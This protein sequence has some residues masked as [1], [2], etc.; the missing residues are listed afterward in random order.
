MQKLWRS[1][2]FRWKGP[3][4]FCVWANSILLDSIKSIKFI[5]DLITTSKKNLRV[6]KN[7]CGSISLKK[8]LQIYIFQVEWPQLLL[9]V[10]Q[11][12]FSRSNSTNNS[13]ATGSLSI[14]IFVHKSSTIWRYP[15]S[16]KTRS[17][18]DEHSTRSNNHLR[19]ID[20]FRP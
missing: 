4:C 8:L 15:L 3:N 12:H 16:K 6:F 13:W 10:S 20:L 7:I 18:K 2:Y 9:C 17:S 1:I 11:F 5:K 14:D 19:S